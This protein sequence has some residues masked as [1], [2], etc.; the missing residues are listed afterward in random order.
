MSIVAHTYPFVIGADTHSRNHALA[1][2][3]PTGEVIDEQI[4]P[5]TKTGLARAVDWACRRT[6]GDLDVL[7]VIEG[8]GT[9]G[10]QLAEAVH[11]AGCSPAEAPRMNARAHRGTGRS[12]PLDARRIAAAALPLDTT[13]LRRPR[14]PDGTRAAIRVLIAARDHMS[15]E[16]TATINA[17]IALARTIDLGIDARNG[18]AASRITIIAAWRTRTEPLAMTT[19]RAEAVRLARR[20]EALDEELH[21]NRNTLTMLIRDTPGAGLLEPPGVSPIPAAAYFAR[22]QQ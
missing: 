7:W 13:Q 16:R 5:T 12:D 9:Y 2:M 22:E 19:A 20:I 3:G 18:L 8:I 21:T 15:S 1:I 11:A 14:D 6:G 4:F 10:A 17:L